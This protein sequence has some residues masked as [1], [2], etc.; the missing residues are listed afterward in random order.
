[1][2]QTG[3]N[4]KPKSA[5]APGWATFRPSGYPGAAV[6]RTMKVQTWTKIGIH[7]IEAPC[8]CRMWADGDRIYVKFCDKCTSAYNL[9][10]AIG[11]Q[12]I[13]FQDKEEHE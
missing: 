5:V 10:M 7:E 13:D 9:W 12:A 11:S 4:N 1:M 3:I 8:G 6:L 2:N